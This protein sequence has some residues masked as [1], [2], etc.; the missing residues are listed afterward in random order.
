[1]LYHADIF[2]RT[3]LITDLIR[4]C[5]SDQVHLKLS[6]L[7]NI[8]IG[9]TTKYSQV[10]ACFYL[11]EN[12][13]WLVAVYESLWFFLYQE[14]FFFACLLSFLKTKFFDV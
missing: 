13:N 1:M 14:N 3:I 7:D 5:I 11:L 8:C 12:I 9:K 6:S 2:G 4:L 10:A